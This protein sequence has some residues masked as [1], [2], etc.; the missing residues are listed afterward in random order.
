MSEREH[1]NRFLAAKDK[2]LNKFSIKANFDDKLF[3]FIFKSN[4]NVFVLHSHKPDLLIKS[5]DNRNDCFTPS[6]ACKNNILEPNHINSDIK[7]E[8]KGES[9]GLD[10][11]TSLICNKIDVDDL[12]KQESDLNKSD[13]KLD[14]SDK[15][16]R[17]EK[18]K[19]EKK[20]ITINVFED[21][22]GLAKKL[23]EPTIASLPN[24]ESIGPQLLK[25]QLS[26]KTEVA[27]NSKDIISDRKREEPHTIQQSKINSV[28]DEDLPHSS[29]CLESN[30]NDLETITYN[31]IPMV[32]HS[33]D[34]TQGYRMLESHFDT[35]ETKKNKFDRYAN[36]PNKKS[37][38]TE[39]DFMKI[40][41]IKSNTQEYLL[42]P[43]SP[44]ELF[45]T[46][47]KHNE[48]EDVEKLDSIFLIL[49]IRTDIFYNPKELYEELKKKVLVEDRRFNPKTELSKC[50]THS[51]NRDDANDEDGDFYQMN[52]EENNRN[53]AT[54]KQ[55]N[56][57]FDKMIAKQPRV[58]ERKLKH[59]NAIVPKFDVPYFANKFQGNVHIPINI[60]KNKDP[61]IER[62]FRELDP[63]MKLPNYNN[64]A[65]NVFGHSSP[66]FNK[67]PHD[68]LN[69]ATPTSI[70]FQQ[71]TPKGF[72]I[73]GSAPKSPAFFNGITPKSIINFNFNQS[74]PINF[75]Q[76]PNNVNNNK[77]DYFANFIASPKSNTITPSYT[78]FKKTDLQNKF[79]TLATVDENHTTNITDSIFN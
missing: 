13:G 15:Q 16:E 35:V 76:S 40:Y 70:N 20:L 11:S 27:F 72:G 29:K 50:I 36:L 42:G 19:K 47:H 14:K 69:I 59:P 64:K 75:L 54:E 55:V 18:K 34:P 7:E 38:F 25:N 23:T 57:K 49:D 60:L 56:N 32:P 67:A 68:I 45:Y 51:S 24:T 77:F 74:T 52:N 63:N 3:P 39:E 31:D 62:A 8:S 9:S 66:K 44:L 48:E 43:F 33:L 2:F 46:L 79:N 26:A 1:L 78:K 53:L 21:D 6:A 22:L 41:G 65:M 10:N 30:V 5:I 73:F 28:R 58:V 37:T 61:N 71:A 17:V 12:F 4:P